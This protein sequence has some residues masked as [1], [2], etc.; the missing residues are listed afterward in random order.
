M[1][2][3]V[4]RAI[5]EDDTGRAC[6]DCDGAVDN[7]THI[8]DGTVKHR[9]RT[10]PYR[11]SAKAAIEAMRV[12][13]DEVKSAG[14]KAGEHELWS[15]PGYHEGETLTYLNDEAPEVIWHAMIDKILGDI[16]S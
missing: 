12:P 14:F 13:T 5:C 8:I 1:I 2:S 6:I 10:C 16:R 11:K 3:V 7:W 15:E 4:A 9:E